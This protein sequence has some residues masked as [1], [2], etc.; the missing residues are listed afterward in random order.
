MNEI[1]RRVKYGAAGYYTPPLRMWLLGCY[2]IDLGKL[3]Q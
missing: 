3:R 1:L 2:I